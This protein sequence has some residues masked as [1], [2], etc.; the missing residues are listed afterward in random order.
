MLSD[1]S[2]G[3]DQVLQSDRY[4][5]DGSE[6]SRYRSGGAGSAPAC[7]QSCTLPAAGSVQQKQAVGPRL[8]YLHPV[9]TLHQPC[10]LRQD[11]TQ[12]IGLRSLKDPLYLTLL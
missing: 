6:C 2:Q 7:D 5:I 11:H 10:R 3:G 9:H 12:A 1:A 8:S 4:R